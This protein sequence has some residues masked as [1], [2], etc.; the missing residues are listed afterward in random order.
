MA[1]LLTKMTVGRIKKQLPNMLAVERMPEERNV[2]YVY[3]PEGKRCVGKPRKIWLDD[4]ENEIKKM[5]FR[6]WRKMVRDLEA[7]KLMLQQARVLYEQRNQWR[8]KEA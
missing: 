2:K 7:W 1:E 4:G 8:R 3:I 6:G 5:G